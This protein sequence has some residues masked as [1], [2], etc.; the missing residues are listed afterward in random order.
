MRLN[1]KRFCGFSRTGEKHQPSNSPSLGSNPPAPARQ[2][3]VQS[4]SPG[5][6]EMGRKSRLFAYSISSPNSE[7]ADLEV[8]I[9]ESLRPCPRKFPFCGDYRQRPVR[10]RLPPEV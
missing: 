2:S 9:A 1:G 3:G 7:F 8:K 6:A 10:S 4:G 5:D